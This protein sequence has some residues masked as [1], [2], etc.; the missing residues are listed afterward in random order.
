MLRNL[1]RLRQVSCR[2]RISMTSSFKKTKV[3]HELLTDIDVLLM[4]EKRIRGEMCHSIN[5]YAKAINKYMTDYDKNKD[6]SYVK[7]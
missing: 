2:S 3:D 1:S 4:V 6:S 7:Y 5:R